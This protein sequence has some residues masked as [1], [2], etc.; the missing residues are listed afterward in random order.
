MYKTFQQVRKWYSQRKAYPY[1]QDYA[2]QVREIVDKFIEYDL[3]DADFFTWKL[4]NDYLY[5]NQYQCPMKTQTRKIHEAILKYGK[6]S[7]FWEEL[8]RT[9]QER[10]NDLMR[11]TYLSYLVG[12]LEG[13]KPRKATFFRTLA[14]DF[15]RKLKMYPLTEKQRIQMWEAE[16]VLGVYYEDLTPEENGEI[17]RVRALEQ[18]ENEKEK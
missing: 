9:K 13:K 6:N 14:I 8:E 5:W 16:R 1:T 18:I 7:L 3:M 17:W 2:S 4:L 10:K 15:R 11:V 12:K